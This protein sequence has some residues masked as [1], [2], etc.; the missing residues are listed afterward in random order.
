MSSETPDAPPEPRYM[1]TVAIPVDADNPADAAQEFAR[2]VTT[3]GLASLT[4]NVEDR[5][6]DDFYLATLNGTYAS[7]DDVLAQLADLDEDDDQPDEPAAEEEEATVN[8]FK[9]PVKGQCKRCGDLAE[10]DPDTRLC[11]QCEQDIQGVPA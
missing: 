9:L 1:V 10:L 4:Y 11:P 2:H 7:R 5:D 3:Y 8:E 6:G